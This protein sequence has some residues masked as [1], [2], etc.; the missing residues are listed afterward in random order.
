[1]PELKV[2][3][4][5]DLG[6]DG[7]GDRRFSG[8]IERINPSTEPGTRAIN[9]Y[10]GLR[11][12]DALLRAG[13]FVSGRI[14][15]ASS[16]PTPTLPMTA[17][18]NE[19]GQS[20]VWTID[21]GKLVRRMVMVGRR[22]DDAGLVELKTALPPGVQVLAARFDNLKEGAPAIVRAPGASS[23]ASNPAPTAARPAG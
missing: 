19:A 16:S 1:V 3:M 5:V 11:N 21:G 18:R 13:M 6:V 10:V 8:R 9:V 14:A 23:N 15:I 4:P 12:H 22:D 2:G 17:V 7:F 20:Y